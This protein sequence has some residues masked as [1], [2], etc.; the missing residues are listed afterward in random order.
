MICYKQYSG[1]HIL[2]IITEMIM[3]VSKVDNTQT[4]W[5]PE[6]QVPVYTML[7]PAPHPQAHRGWRWVICTDFFVH[8]HPVFNSRPTPLM[9]RWEFGRLVD[10]D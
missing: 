2:A 4:L 8:V 10:L 6:K 5:F 1:S 9:G 7:L 3:M